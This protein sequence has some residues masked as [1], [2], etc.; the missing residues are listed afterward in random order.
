M[1][2]AAKPGRARRLTRCDFRRF[3]PITTR[4]SD[5]DV[6]G[7]VNNVV[8]YSWFDTAVTGWLLEQNLLDPQISAIICVVAETSCTYFE[9]VSFPQGITA[10]IAIDRIGRS[11]AT[12]RIGIFADE[13]QDVAAQ[14][15]FTHVYVDRIGQRPIAI[16]AETRLAMELLAT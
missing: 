11:S 8:Y 9:S 5:N 14:G 10:G 4:W 7:H 1:N 15:L 3:R 2:D 6:F 12:Y 13:S 16:P